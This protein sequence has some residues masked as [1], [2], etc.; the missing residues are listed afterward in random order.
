MKRFVLILAVIMLV[1]VCP[2][3]ALSLTEYGASLLVDSFEN[4]DIGGFPYSSTEVATVMCTTDEAR[5]GDMSVL[6][7]WSALTDGISVKFA[8]IFKFN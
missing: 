3:N 8:D 5:K 7:D 4:A 6:L 2:V 1:A